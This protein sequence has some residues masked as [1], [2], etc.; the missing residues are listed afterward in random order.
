MGQLILTKKRGKKGVVSRDVDEAILISPFVLVG[1]LLLMVGVFSLI[2][3]LKFNDSV[4]KGYQFQK[5]DSER[6][7]LMEENQKIQ[8]NLAELTAIESLNAS[9][10]VQ[11]MVKPAKV[12]YLDE[13]TEVK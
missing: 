13:E 6:K 12:F 9:S 3:L 7:V 2:Q 8:R 10:K 5:L 1:V 4:T 11:N